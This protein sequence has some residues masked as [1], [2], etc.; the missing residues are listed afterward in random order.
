MNQA[1]D[2]SRILGA[3]LSGDPDKTALIFEDE[4]YSYRR[5]DEESSALA[6]RLA[7][8]GLS[9]EPLA[10]VLP[11]GPDIV[12]LYLAC[13]KAGVVAMPLNRRYA[14]PE[15]GR[16]LSHSGAKR[17]IVEADR[18]GLLDD[19]AVDKSAL[20]KIYV[21]GG[22]A[23][24]GFENYSTLRN[25]A[26][27]FSATPQAPYTPSVIFYT[28]GSTGE[29]KGVT[30]TH[31]SVL[32]IVDSGSDA[33][34][35][36]SPADTILVQEPQCHISGFMMTFMVLANGGT[37]IVED[38]FDVDSY[39]A[40]L[41]GM[42]PSLI[43]TY[44]DVILQL[45]D[46]GRC[47][48]D[49]FSSLRGLYTGGDDL[50]SALQK[51]YLD[52]TGKPIMLGYGMTEAIWL[53]IAREANLERA[54]FI[55]KTVAGAR[56]RIVDEDGEDLPDGE[57]GEIWIKGPMVMARYWNDGEATHEAFEDGWFK[58]GDCAVRQPGGDYYYT[59]RIK[60]IIIRDTSNIS[61]GE[62]E[63]A[64]YKNPGVKEAAVI[65]VPDGKEGHVPVAFVVPREGS[66]LTEKGVIEAAGRE[67]A[68]YKLP[69]RVYFIDAIPLTDSGKI[70]HKRLYDLLPGT[71]SS[72]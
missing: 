7:S 40:R 35:G 46:S 62:V 51:R 48:R 16:A 39:L 43:V 61:P 13:Y 50:P 44:V 54:G 8:E 11:N 15:L 56:L 27:S 30:H 17:L 65:G 59:G 10:F 67:I 32:G 38:G 71:G 69:T 63:S 1:R 9:G 21:L 29:P 6:A 45:L 23:S 26:G 72:N 58:S 42:R 34:S 55:G 66:T 28:S 53:T 4:G 2:L 37:V 70:N 3:G 24:G 20:E 18:L 33:L 31:S 60:N 52:L 19:P 22:D 14:A 25:G 49:T 41:T 5:L 68:A 36:I 64:I 12:V 47:T 57:A